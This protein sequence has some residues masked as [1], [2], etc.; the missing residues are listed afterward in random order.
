MKF[1]KALMLIATLLFLL[2]AVVCFADDLPGEWMPRWEIG[3]WWIV[4]RTVEGSRFTGRPYPSWSNFILFRFEVTGVGQVNGKICYV[5]ERRYWPIGKLTPPE[6]RTIFFLCK[7]DLCL[8]RLTDYAYSKKLL[9]SYS[10]DYKCNRGITFGVGLG[11]WINLPAFPL[12]YE[13]IRAVSLTKP[14]SDPEASYVTQN[15]SVCNI[16]NFSQQ[17]A[18]SE[19][20]EVSSDTL[21]YHVILEGG[22]SEKDRKKIGVNY[23]EQLWSPQF[24]WYLY[25]EVGHKSPEGTKK[26]WRKTWLFDCSSF[27]K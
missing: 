14:P 8:V 19:I 6:V 13:G 9:K 3:D 24:P 21:C 18:D 22:G 10:I 4:K 7:E 1:K 2:T 15:V 5:L 23:A 20:V 11:G 26:L 17:L 25:E 16:G 12:T 27:H